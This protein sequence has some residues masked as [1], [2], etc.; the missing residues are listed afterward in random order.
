MNED[1]IER[2]ISIKRDELRRPLEQSDILRSEGASPRMHRSDQVS[3]SSS[4]VNLDRESDDRHSPRN[5]RS[6]RSRNGRSS[7]RDSSRS[8]SR[9]RSLYRK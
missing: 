5:V 8:R 2:R 1:E 9:S 4:A 3:D 6:S 7:S